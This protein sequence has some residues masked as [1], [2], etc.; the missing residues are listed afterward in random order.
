MKKFY[1]VAYNNDYA[2][3][4]TDEA[5]RDW[6]LAAVVYFNSK[7]ERDEWC[8]GDYLCRPCTAK[9]V[10]YMAYGHME[11]IERGE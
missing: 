1:A 11:L 3:N 5:L 2:L 10:R 9:F 8:D 4:Y 6:N 7:R